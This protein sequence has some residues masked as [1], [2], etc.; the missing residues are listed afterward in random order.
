MGVHV[1][2]TFLVD[3]INFIFRSDKVEDPIEEQH[4]EEEE[5]EEEEE[6]GHSS[7][8]G[9]RV[10]QQVF[11]FRLGELPS[12]VTVYDA[13]GNELDPDKPAEGMAPLLEKDEKDEKGEGGSVYHHLVVPPGGVVLCRPSSITLSEENN[14]WMESVRRT[15]LCNCKSIL[16]CGG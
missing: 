3:H 8:W 16:N 14:G 2:R 4:E 15:G 5:E 1:P 13:H 12:E 7:S 9:P 11:D 6:A 10:K